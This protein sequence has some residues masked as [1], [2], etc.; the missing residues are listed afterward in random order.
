MWFLSAI[1]VVGKAIDAFTAYFNKR[2]D[3]DL[4]KYKVKGNIDIK[5]IEADVAIIQARAK[6][7]E[8]MKDD[9]GT[10]VARVWIMI[11]ASVYFGISFYY[12]AFVDLLP[13]VFIWKPMEL[14]ASLEYVVYGII[15][16]LFVTAWRGNR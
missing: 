13:G 7:A 4:E 1:P 6:L 14:P 10:K 3:V 2:Q 5:A 11:P 9:P 12:H 8:A 16:Y 15:G